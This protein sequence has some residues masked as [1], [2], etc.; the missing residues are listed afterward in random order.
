[1][2]RVIT[3][4]CLMGVLASAGHALSPLPEQAMRG[5]RGGHVTLFEIHEGQTC[6]QTEP[7]C[8]GTECVP[9]TYWECHDTV[10]YSYYTGNVH[11]Q[12]GCNG[13]PLTGYGK[14]TS[15]KNLGQCV[16]GT[17]FDMCISGSFVCATL[18]VYEDAA[19]ARLRQSGVSVYAQAC[20]L[21]ELP[22]PPGLFATPSGS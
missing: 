20:E 4:G 12:D 7:D 11:W 8:I 21:L 17:A 13:V 19:C 3:L 1:M 10:P 2:F 22:P 15:Y 18:D 5:T 14:W 6:L 16:Q 9:I